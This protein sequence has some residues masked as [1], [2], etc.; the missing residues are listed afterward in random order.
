MRGTIKA[1][2]TP[3]PGVT[4][5]ASNT[6]TGKKVST[7]T[8]PDGSFALTLPSRGRYVIKAEQAAFAPSTK[9]VVITPETPQATVDADLMLASRAQMLAAQQQQGAAQQ[10]AAALA[11]R[12]M[13]SLSVTESD[14]GGIPSADTSGQTGGLPLNGAGADAPTES[15]SVSGAMGQAQNFG[16]NPDEL[17]DRIHEIRERMQREGGNNGNMVFLGPGE[18]GGFGGPGGGGPRGGPGG[19]GPM[20]MLGGRMVGRF[21]V[22][23]PHGSI[24]YSTDNSIFDAAPF[25]INGLGNSVAPSQKSDY[26]Q[27]RFGV[28]IGSPLKIPHV[29]NSEKTFV[30]FN[31]TGGRNE[32]PYDN[33]STVPTVAERQG[34]FSALGRQLIDP[35]TGQP[36]PGN[37]ITNINPAA[38][39]LLQFIPLPNLPGTANNFHYVSS[40]QQNNDQIAIRL[41]HNFGEGA[42]FMPGGGRG[43]RGGRRLQ[44]NINFNLNYSD[45]NNQVSNPFPTLLGTTQSSGINAGAGW[46]ASKNRLTNNLHFNYNRSHSHLSNLFQ[47]KENVAAF[48]GIDGVSQD[49]FNYGVPTLVFNNFQSVND[50]G[51]SLINN[52]TFSWSDSVIWRRGKHNIRLGG[53]FRRIYNDI[54]SA[55]N[56]RG[57][58]TFTDAGTFPGSSSGFDFANFLLGLPAQTSIQ[59][60]SA[61]YNFRQNSW[62]LFAE[63]DWRVTGS[64]S[65][66]LG[67]RYE[68]VSPFSEANNRIVNLDLNP[69]ITAAV[70]VF[71][72]GAG[73]FTGGFPVTVV[74]PDRNNVAPRVGFAW[75]AMKKTVVR[76]GYGINYNTGQYGSIVQNLA[77]QPPFAF[78][79]TNVTTTSQVLTLRNGFPAPT[80][81]VTNNFAVDKNYK[82]GYVQIWN[83]NIQREITPSLLLN[84]GYNGSKGTDLDMERAPNRLPNEQLRIAGV[85]PFILETSQGD[86]ILHA[87]TVQVRKRMRH[88]MAAQGT[89]VFSKSLD[90]A[91]SI[92]GV[93]TPIVAQNDLDLAAERGLSSFDQRHKFT[94]NFTYELPFGTGKKWLNNNG[95]WLENVFGDWLWSGNVTLA[96]GLPFT[97]RVLGSPLDIAQGLNGTLRADIVGDPYSGTCPNGFPV[98]TIECWFNTS[99]FVKPPVGAFGDARRNSIIGPGQFTFGMSVSK[100]LFAKDTRAL[101]LR[102]SANNIFNHPEYTS[103]GTIVGTPTYGQVI[104][105]GPMRTV[106]LSARYRF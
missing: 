84:L 44:N 77:F 49:P 60:G 42:T 16:M 81:A 26:A 85:Q 31:W 98:G 18:G 102:L 35:T 57:S 47:D 106:N 10:V 66:N 72:G 22:N 70:P 73:P 1:G 29:V 52:Q 21:N 74:E 56:A 8:S 38:Q 43:G 59:G 78:T 96:S 90:N 11:N 36:L 99:A 100:T 48:A 9:E 97:P 94:G 17:E 28:T 89:Y 53:D 20:L 41:I 101:E 62:D 25:Q 71:P 103:I 24:F 79:E 5:T 6:L 23:Q 95:G 50:T 51:A 40:L 64:L 69:T 86:S 39:A 34:D 30:F 61:T 33:F 54:R 46:V 37:Q 7:A 65:L 15:V 27:H 82:L 58:F 63:D 3:L 87:A 88:G 75:R 80:A 12:G 104:A 14:N 2:V 13:Q 55:Q 68:Y 19:G 76:G 93:G 4:V 92:G 67:L 45:S 83:L 105:A 32:N 91:S